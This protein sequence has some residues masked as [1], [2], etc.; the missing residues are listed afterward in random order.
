MID[1]KNVTRK[2][3]VVMAIGGLWLSGCGNSLQG[4]WENTTGPAPGTITATFETTRYTMLSTNHSIDSTGTRTEL[5]TTTES[6][7]Y[8]ISGTLLAVI[9]EGFVVLDENGGEKPV[10]S[11]MVDGV[12]S[13][14]LVGTYYCSAKSREYQADISSDILT[15]S[16]ASLSGPVSFARKN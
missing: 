9:T 4:T 13:F 3:S 15:L 6:G 7:T 16:G 1:R 5:G 11:R 8:T 12:D 2:L 14:C 10:E